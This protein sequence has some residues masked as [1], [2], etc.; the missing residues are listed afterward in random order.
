MK[1]YFYIDKEGQQKGPFTEDELRD[2]GISADTYVWT[3]GM[4]DWKRASEAEGLENVIMM[5]PQFSAGA[6]PPPYPDEEE[7]AERSKPENY[8][9][10]AILSAL[11]CFLPF[12]IVAIVYALQVDRAWS[13]GDVEGAVKSSEKAKLWCL[14]SLVCLAVPVALMLLFVFAAMIFGFIGVGFA[15]F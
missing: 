4:R 2:A 6:V 7:T 5:P 13:D 12:G 3:S 8:L 9:L 15:Y 14:I 10:W 1:Q 11:F